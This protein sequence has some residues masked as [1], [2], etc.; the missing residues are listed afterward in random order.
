MKDSPLLP[1]NLERIIPKRVITIQHFSFAGG[2]F[3]MPWNQVVVM[4]LQDLNGAWLLYLIKKDNQTLLSFMPGNL[5]ELQTT[6]EPAGTMIVDSLLSALYQNN[7][8]YDSAYKYL[9]NF[10]VLKDSVFNPNKIAQAQ[11]LSFNETL[12]QQQLEQ[13]KKEAEQQYK[14]RLKFYILG[15]VIFVFLIIAFLLLRNLRNKR[16]A[17]VLLNNR[18]E[19]IQNA[20]QS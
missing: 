7:H 20:Y 16:K 6:D 11:N 4:C 10:V 12:Q 18:K 13:A 14:N 5:K 2:A 1:V 19:E 17:N 9:Q 3:L 8:Q 15:A